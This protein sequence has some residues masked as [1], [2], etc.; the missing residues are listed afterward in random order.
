MQVIVNSAM[1]VDGKIATHQGDSAI[2]SKDDLI[3]VHKLRDSVDGIIVGIS[4]VLADNPRLTIRLGRKQPKEKHLTR[5]IID[6]MGRIPL[7]SQ[8]LRTASKIKTIV[9]VTKLAHMNVRRKIKKTGAIVIVA[10]T[11]TVDLKRVLWTIQKMGIKKI[12][13]EG[14]GEINWSLFS[15][16]IVNE[17]IVTIAPKIVGGRQATT[18]VEG[19]GYSR[20]SQGLKLQLKKV[21]MQNSGE[22][23]L[24]Y[25]L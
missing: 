15:L 21:R 14:G 6:S 24:H 10:G 1:T 13:V 12:L 25:K 9:A 20:V 3:R 7:D 2:S 8:I 18:L 16:G 5:I 17:L 23:V 19:E 22:L 4:T 11:N